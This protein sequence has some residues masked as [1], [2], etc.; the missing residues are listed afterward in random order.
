MEVKL[1]HG[2]LIVRSRGHQAYTQDIL[3]P[4]HQL[5]GDEP[6]DKGGQDLGPYPY[7]FL[8]AA[9]GTCTSI[10]LQMYA[11]YKGLDLRQIE[12]HL[13]HQK[14]PAPLG[15][16]KEFPKGQDHIERR[17]HLEGDLTPEQREAC[18]QIANKCPVNR[19]LN[20]EIVV[21]TLLE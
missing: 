18:L 15:R 11:K 4:H 17:V 2:E 3:M 19:T 9:L 14:K 13:K 12:V 6:E 16:E 20:S 5:I 21:N 7:E 8:L 10:T 1:E